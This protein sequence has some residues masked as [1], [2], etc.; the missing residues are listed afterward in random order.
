MNHLLNGMNTKQKE[1]I[2]CTQGPLLIM[3]GA[4]SG[5]TRVLTHRIAYL[6]EEKNV[7]P[8]NILAIT[9]TNKAAREMKERLEGLIGQ[10]SRDMWVSTFHSMCVRIL[11]REAEL[12]G[13][14]RQFNIIDTAEQKLL[15]KR[16]LKDL[17]YDANKFS[18]KMILG[19]ISDAKNRLVSAKMM[20]KSAGNYLEEVL[21]SC[22]EEYEKRLQKNQ[23]FDFDDL[24]MKTVQLFKQRPDVLEQY[25]HKFQY[26]HVDEYQ[27]TNKAQYELVLQLSHYFKNICVVGD[28]DQSI[29]GWRGADM[30]NI[31]NFEKDFPTAQTILLEQNYRST[32]HILH[33]ANS[34]IIKNQERIPKKLWTDNEKGEH[35]I[36]YC[37]FSEKDE[38][39]F[40]SQT[41]KRCL[42]DAQSMYGYQDVAVLYR[43]NAQSRVIEESLVT[44]NI[45]YKIV[46]GLRFYDRKE[47]KDLVA[48]LRLIA[49]PDDDL[50]FE[51]VVNE[52]KR[53]VGKASIEK[54]QQFATMHDIS[55][56]KAAQNVLATDVST[57]AQKGILS[58]VRVIETCQSLV[59]ELSL[60][61]LV[62]KVMLLSG[63]RDALN[64]EKTL[65]SQARL[66]NIEE[67]KSITKTFDDAYEPELTE[68]QLH[69]NVEDQHISQESDTINQLLDSLYSTELSVDSKNDESIHHSGEDVPL[70]QTFNEKFLEEDM[71][72]LQKLAQFLSDFSLDGT[73]QE[74]NQQGVT[75]MTLHAAKG[76]EFP[77]VFIVG[78]EETIFP[79]SRSISEGD[80]E[81]ERRLMYVGITRAEKK[82]FLTHASSRLFYGK[83]QRNTPSRFLDE[84]DENI[85]E[86]TDSTMYGRK[87]HVGQIQY[88]S[89]F[90]VHKEKVSIVQKQAIVSN[91]KDEQISW[92][93]GQQ[94]NHKK[95]GIGRIVRISGQGEDTMLD[96]AFDGQGIKTLLASF[97]PITK[98]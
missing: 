37:A 11:R 13:Y 25:Q 32:Q 91:Q 42:Q 75:L 26:I 62:D 24:I 61:Q 5:K 36:S 48:Y 59:E 85:V 69:S 56:F 80:L 72:K 66:Q 90:N 6:I 47:I 58:F 16:I 39:S 54:L 81:E 53:N 65:E 38:A 41:I 49:N 86:R 71:I 70:E 23:L 17:D 84:I 83:N 10:I 50:C 46:G 57:K 55:L 98:A 96:I 74:D 44:Y 12:I 94:V 78:L 43:T 33:A 35:I 63:Y 77:L 3:A 95:W 73:V 21:A 14:S 2:Q 64:N 4:G 97:A 28:A 87:S 40:V 15:M 68:S 82:L 60:T 7:N 20:R 1:A 93:V 92:S 29:Y 27:D 31:L 18:D 76:L 22:Y 19:V 88:S 34:V 45:P 67:F 79:T 52:P 8:W 51:R 9:F 30:Q 89:A